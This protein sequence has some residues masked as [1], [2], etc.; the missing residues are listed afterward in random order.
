MHQLLSSG[1]SPS[2]LAD[3]TVVAL[4]LQAPSAAACRAC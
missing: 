1:S 3:Q 2:N 4:L